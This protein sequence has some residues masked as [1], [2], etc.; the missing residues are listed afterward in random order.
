MQGVRTLAEML[1]QRAAAAPDAIACTYLEDQGKEASL[2]YAGLDQ[3]A[4]AVAAR[5]SGELARG[6]RALLLYPPGLSFIIGFFGCLYAGVIAV[7]AYP[8]RGARSYKRLHGILEDSGAR[9]ALTTDQGKDL[10]ELAGEG[11][12]GGQGGTNGGLG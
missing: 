8:P 11:V 7:P 5:L 3:A 6:D 4:R 2:T 12:L 9:V 1:R 10:A